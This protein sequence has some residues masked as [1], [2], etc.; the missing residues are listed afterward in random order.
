[1]FNLLVA[2]DT[3]IENSRWPAGGALSETLL[4]AACYLGADSSFDGTRYS[5]IA[6]DSGQATIVN[7]KAIGQA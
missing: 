2:R 5:V 6:M 1:M 4:K 3:E 7:T